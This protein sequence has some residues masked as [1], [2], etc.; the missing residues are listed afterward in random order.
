M[1]ALRA[2]RVDSFAVVDVPIE[3]RETVA[4]LAEPR[5][6][7][8]E[9][10]YCRGADAY[11]PVTGLRRNFMFDLV[12]G[13][14]YT[15]TGQLVFPIGYLRSVSDVLAP[16]NLSIPLPPPHPPKASRPNAFNPNFE[17]MMA[18]LGL[19]VAGNP[20]RHRQDEA[21]VTIVAALVGGQGGVV[22]APTAYGKGFLIQGAVLALPEARFDVVAPSEGTVR[23]IFRRLHRYI[24]EVGQVGAGRSTLGHRVTVYCADSLHKAPHEGDDEA[25]FVIFD[26]VHEAAAPS[27]AQKLSKYQ[28]AVKVGLTASNNLRFDGRDHI[29]EG[30]FGP[31]IFKMGYAE[32]AAHELVAPMTVEW[33]DNAQS[34]P[35][36][37]DLSDIERSR[38][39]IWQNRSRNMLIADAARR[40]A[41]QGMQV[42]I[43]VN[44]TEHAFHLKRELPEFSLAYDKVDLVDYN[45]YLRQELTTQEAEP[46][47]TKQRRQDLIGLF[48]RREL[49]TA[50]ATGI[51]STGVD[52]V[53]LDVV[54]RA[55]GM[56]SDIAS[57]QI[58]GRAA[59]I[60]PHTDKQSG[61]VVDLTDRFDV[62]LH[63]RARRRRAR[64]QSN[65]WSETGWVTSTRR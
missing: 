41:A 45:R 19:G 20:F 47:M 11:D 15:E 12:P 44:T 57:V 18:R 1:P 2:R 42:L 56:A 55:D 50:I 35:N 27:I 61:V 52:F 25:D 51:W 63:N 16:V 65:D 49:M 28:R 34:G 13:F 37:R 4:R 60:S 54:I 32:A 17:S 9:K 43:M 6:S 29:I 39:G 40:F 24:P 53:G 14:K 64:Y 38:H 3:H 31:T 23:N 8:L 26:E 33:I 5:L 46:M 7:Y 59:R 22:E 36:L 10:R 58:P 30:L 21:I 62:S 48:E